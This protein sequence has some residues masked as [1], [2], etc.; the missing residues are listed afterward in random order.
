MTAAIATINN[1]VE[2]RSR[3]VRNSKNV[4]RIDIG[5]FGAVEIIIAT[6]MKKNINYF[7]A[8]QRIYLVQFVWQEISIG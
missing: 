5:I 2:R 6:S 3:R 8:W 1:M 7:D 4:I